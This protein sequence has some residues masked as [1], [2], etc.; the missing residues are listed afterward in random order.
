MPATIDLPEVLKRVVRLS[1]T[2]ESNHGL[3]ESAFTGAVQAQRGQLERWSF[4]M[5]FRKMNRAEAQAAIAFF[6]RLEGQLNRFRMADPA[7][8]KPLGKGTGNP[9]ASTAT[10]AGSRTLAT[11]GWLPNV[12][13]QLREGDWVQI[14]DQLS[15]VREDVDSDAAGAAAL[16]LWPK[17]MLAVPEGTPI[18]LRPAKGIFRFTSEA[19]S[20]DLTAAD[21]NKPFSFRM[22]GVQEVLLP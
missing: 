19:P 2:M 7:A 6:M 18:I 5:E 22:S 20:F 8:L 16:D 15:R 10:T 21:T 9:V 1:W 3:A 4:T 11:T 17:L 14:G 12:P 13:G